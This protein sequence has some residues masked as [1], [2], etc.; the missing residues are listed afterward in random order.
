MLRLNR[1]FFQNSHLAKDNASLDLVS[2]ATKAGFL[3][4]DG[5]GVYSLLHLGLSAQ[6]QMEQRLRQAFSAAGAGEVR[7]ALL[8]DLALW[9]ATGRLAAYEGELMTVRARG[10]TEYALG[11]TAEELI[12]TVAKDLFQGQSGERWVFQM[13]TKWRDELRCRAGL[14]R[15]R[16][17]T[18]FDAYSFASDE[19]ALHR[20]HEE[21]Q[22]LLLA[23]FAGLGLEARRQEADSGQMGGGFSEEIQVRS[24]LGDETAADRW[25]E[26]G[27]SFVLGDRYSRALGYTDH[28]GAAVQMGC[29]GVGL[30]R[31]LMAWLERHRD[32]RGFFGTAQF[33]AVDTVVV[34]LNQHK[35]GV[36]ERAL[37]LAHR[38]EAAGRSVVLD[39]RDERA[40][41]K[42]ADSE[43]LG[44]RWRIVV[45]DRALAA[46]RY[47]RT[48]R[49]TGVTVQ[50]DWGTVLDTGMTA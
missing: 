2:L 21:A 4:K 44:A 41:K 27:H 25:L 29:Q 38:L 9:Q 50:R 46:D 39:D 49:A 22:T 26:V 5:A 30:S 42:L 16:E 6:A 47:D 3:H 18:M 19:A 43:L 12:C 45:S 20:L 37:D 13:G 10:G 35:A 7:L 33:S 24:E 23:F 34:A 11:A 17:F 31:S 28:Q 36:L 1:C 14:V 32:E 40:G 8:Q 15:A 48:E